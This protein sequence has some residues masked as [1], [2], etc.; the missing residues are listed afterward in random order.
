MIPLGINPAAAKK[1]ASFAAQ[2]EVNA[3]YLTD[4]GATTLQRPV[5]QP[6][7]ASGSPRPWPSPVARQASTSTMTTQ[8]HRR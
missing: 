6:T 4:G 8:P 3:V 7:M 5:V 2:G 1:S